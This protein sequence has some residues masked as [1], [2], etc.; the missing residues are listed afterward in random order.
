LWADPSLILIIDGN[1]G[2]WEQVQEYYENGPSLR[3]IPGNVVFVLGE[4]EN[5]LAVSKAQ[6]PDEE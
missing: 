2:S 5:S 3:L 4:S 6:L 1:L